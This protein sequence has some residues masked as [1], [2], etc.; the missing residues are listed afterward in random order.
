MTTISVK[1][2]NVLYNF[3]SVFLNNGIACK[4]ICRGPTKEYK[5]YKAE[6]N[7]CRIVS[8]N[9]LYISEYIY[10]IYKH[11]I[12]TKH[13]IYSQKTG[14][15]WKTKSY[16]IFF[17][18]EIFNRCLICNINCSEN[19]NIDLYL[20]KIDEYLISVSP[21]SKCY[22]QYILNEKVNN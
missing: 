9:I 10:T 12:D 3:Q 1:F 4:Y 6:R 2:N 17:L 14:L 22:I 5:L 16:I 13:F 19:R 8:L 21:F 7:S 18:N 15:E 20:D 11:I